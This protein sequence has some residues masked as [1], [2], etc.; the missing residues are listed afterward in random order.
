MGSSLRPGL[1]P[2]ANH[3]GAYGEGGLN[4][5]ERVVIEHHL[6]ECAPCRR[7]LA[8]AFGSQPAAWRVAR[9]SARPA[10][11]WWPAGAA[12]AATLLLGLSLWPRR[13]LGP[14]ATPLPAA[15]VVHPLA[16]AILPAPPRVRHLARR[17]APAPI[18]LA[19]ATLPAPALPLPAVGVPVQPALDFS[20]LT[21][22]FQ[23]QAELTRVRRAAAAEIASW[24]GG[25]PAPGPNP[26]AAVTVATRT[27]SGSAPA[28][29]TSPEAT[30]PALPA[31]AN[32]FSGS[33]RS[34]SLIGPLAPTHSTGFGW[35]IARGGELLR[36]LGAGLWAA[37][38]LVPGVHFLALFNSGSQVWAGGLASQLYCSFDAGE[39]W[40]QVQLPGV[41]QPA[42]PLR[43]ILFRDAKHGRVIAADGSTWVTSDGGATWTK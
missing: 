43:E 34:V 30:W 25:A 11:R 27:V 36:S 23:D 19:A 39:H 21:T 4:A 33:A 37:V 15:T 28:T 22:G 2:D 6:A 32:G 16:V 18:Q 12:V 7:I 20:P 13:A 38:P 26:A 40:S 1:H 29:L 31:L 9:S 17:P 8:C 35:A 42:P 3:L 14:Q 5:P 24:T 10:G 41:A